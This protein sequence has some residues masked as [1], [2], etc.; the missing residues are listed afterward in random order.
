MTM[1][2]GCHSGSPSTPTPAATPAREPASDRPAPSASE[3]ATAVVEL[4]IDEIAS[5]GNLRLRLLEV[6]DSR[7][8]RG[9]QCIWEGQVT[10][11]VEVSRQNLMPQ[12]V[13]LMLRAGVEMWATAVAGFELR[14]LNVAPYPRDGVTP[15]RGAHLA[16]VEIRPL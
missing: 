3:D 5:H 6:N 13:E 11:T 2:L 12:T 9:A 4:R 14:L 1:S 10:A 15:E 7:C 16:T 8:P